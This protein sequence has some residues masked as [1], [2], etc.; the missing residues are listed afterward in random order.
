MPPV[1]SPVATIDG[2]YVVNNGDGTYT[3]VSQSGA[4]TT[5]PYPAGA[6]AGSIFGN[7]NPMVLAGGFAA[8]L[9]LLKR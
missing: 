8:L 7:V 9:F 2:G 1:G 4:S 3:L 5:L 6:N